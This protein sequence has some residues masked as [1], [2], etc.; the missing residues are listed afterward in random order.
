[1]KLALFQ[2][3]QKSLGMRIPDLNYLCSIIAALSGSAKTI[4]NLIASASESNSILAQILLTHHK[5]SRY[6][7][8][9]YLK[10]QHRHAK[11]KER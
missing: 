4:G 10:F 7:I 9:S 5:G 1:M 3:R 2:L 8:L 11:H 6:Q